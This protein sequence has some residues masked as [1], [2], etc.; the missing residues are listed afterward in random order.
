MAADRS[1]GV[2]VRRLFAAAGSLA[3]VALAAGCSSSSTLEN[4]AVGSGAVAHVGDTLN[5]KTQGGRDFHISAAKVVDPSQTVNQSAPPKGKRFI[6]VVFDVTNT[7]S[8]TLSTNGD[9]DAN[10]IGSNGTTYSPTHHDLSD[11]AGSTVKV[12]LAAGKSGTTCVAF[13]V[14]TSVSVSKVQ[15]YPAAGSGPDYGEWLVP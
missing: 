15:F 10:I 11:C 4:H 1:L 8:A 12:Q 3:L 5:L 14:A 7:S 13:Q 9:L 6:A 2:S